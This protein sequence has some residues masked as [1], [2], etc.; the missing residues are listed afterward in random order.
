MKKLTFVSSPAT[1]VVV[2]FKPVWKQ[3][4]EEYIWEQMK[5]IYVAFGKPIPPKP[6]NKNNNNCSK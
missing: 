4:L 6:G 3:A 1:V 2:E 5:A